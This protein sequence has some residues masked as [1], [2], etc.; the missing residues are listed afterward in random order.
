MCFVSRCANVL[1]RIPDIDQ[2][3]GQCSVFDGG[4]AVGR[5]SQDRLAGAWRLGQPHTLVYDRVEYHIAEKLPHLL[6][7][8]SA[9]QSVLFD[10]GQ[11]NA[12]YAQAV[13][14]ETLFDDVCRFEEL[15]EAFGG[16]IMR[17]NQCNNDYQLAP[18]TVKWWNS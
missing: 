12:R 11:Q 7:Y 5:V 13:G 9:E 14:T 3:L 1:R 15:P 18:E 6:Y 16:I 10:Q 4:F 2:L 17:L 8:M